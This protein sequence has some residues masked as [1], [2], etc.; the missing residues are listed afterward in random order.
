VAI[1][2]WITGSSSWGF[3]HVGQSLE[4]SYHLMMH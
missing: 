3:R 4:D 2:S 1:L